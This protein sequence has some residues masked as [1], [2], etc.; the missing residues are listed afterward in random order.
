MTTYSCDKCRNRIQ[1]ETMADAAGAFAVRLA[2][3]HWGRRGE[4]RTLR[5]DCWAAD[6]SSAEYDAFIGRPGRGI[7][8]GATVGGNV[9]FVVHRIE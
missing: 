7:D 6:G 2:R 4:V 3:R 5:A 8:R 9:R 1:A